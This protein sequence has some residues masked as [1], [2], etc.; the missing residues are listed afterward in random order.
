MYR[1]FF[2]TRL[3][4]ASRLKKTCLPKRTRQ[5]TRERRLWHGSNIEEG[6][7]RVVAKSRPARNLVSMTLNRSPTVP[8]S[9]SSH[10]PVKL[11]GECFILDSLSTGKPVARSKGHHRST[12]D[13]SPIDHLATRCRIHGQS[14]RKRATENRS[15][16][17]R[18]NGADRNQRNDLVNIYDCVHEGS[19]TSRRTFTCYEER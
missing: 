5:E 14:L 17:E 13:P 12:F 3:F 18:H 7:G 6:D 8:S 2:L 15:S 9:S 11:R 10:S 19:G 4:S 16:K 1:N